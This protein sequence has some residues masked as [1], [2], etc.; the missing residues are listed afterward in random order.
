MSDYARI[1][2][3]R[4]CGSFDLREYLNLG[5]QPL[6]NGLLSSP[7]IVPP[8]YPLEVLYCK[9]C[10]L[11]M[12]SVVVDPK[13]MYKD[14]PYQSSVSDTFRNHCGEMARTIKRYVKSNSAVLDIA[15]NDGCLLQEF[16]KEGYFTIGVEPSKN[17]CEIAES[18]GISTINDFWG[19][20]LIPRVP[21]VH[22]ITATNVF[23]H[24]DDLKGFVEAVR[25]S[26]KQDGIFII[27][28][29]Y[30]Y[31]LFSQNQFDTIYHEHLSYFL[32]DPIRVLLESCGMRAFRV[33]RIPIHG[34]S[35]RIYASKGHITPDDSVAEIED[36]EWENRMYKFETYKKYAKNLKCLKD[37]FVSLLKDFRNRKKKVM[38]YG[39]SAKG[40][41]LMNYCGINAS[42][43]QSIVDDT[44]SKQGKFT[45][46]SVI[47]IVGRDNFDTNH[48][49]YIA[50]LS[51]NFSAE[52][53]SKTKAHKNRGGKYIIPIPQVRIE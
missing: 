31:S 10:S 22:V 33:D 37:H 17:L 21:A 27:E 40:I 23:A 45:P 2:N 24:V 7:E 46:G 29:P 48:P 8:K 35:I 53:K 30:L 13:I 50:L 36:F 41:S 52:L 14:Y 12:L 19:K 1:R 49:D 6:A 9:N 11:S 44:P 25:D 16:K 34:G 47:P 38:G 4:I 3:C 28:V 5:K 20:H 51:W 15:S 26:L 18:K 32:F 43:I 42:H 39:A